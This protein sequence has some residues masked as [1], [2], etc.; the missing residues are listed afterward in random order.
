MWKS[1]SFVNK[2]LRVFLFAFVLDPADDGVCP[3]PTN[4][5]RCFYNVEKGLRLVVAP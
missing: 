1:E 2:G 5:A 4:K 3:G